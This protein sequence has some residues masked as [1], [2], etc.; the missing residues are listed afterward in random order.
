MIGKG[1]KY[2]I[3]FAHEHVP[4]RMPELDAIASMFGIT[5]KFIEQ[6]NKEPYAIVELAS[7]E[8]AKKL[9]SRSVLIRSV[10][11]LWTHAG[12]IDDVCDQVKK[13]PAKFWDAYSGEDQSFKFSVEIFGKRKVPREVKV[14]KIEKFDFLPLNGPIKMENPDHTYHLI[15][16][17]GIV[18]NYIPEKPHAVFFGRWIC[19]GQRFL[20]SHLALRTRKFIANTSMDPT[21]SVIMANMAKVKKSHLILD[22]F[23]GSGSLL[24]PAA[25]FGA[26]VLGT[27][28]DY[29][30]LHGKAK[31]SRCNEKQRA[32]DESVQAN[33]QQ[34]GCE[35]C[36]VDVV[37]ADASLPLWRAEMRLDAIITDPPYGIR[38]ATER[39]GTHKTYDI[40]GHLAAQ[41]V[42]SKV[43]YCLKDVLCD[44]LNFSAHHLCLNGR[45]VFWMPIYN[46]DFSE[47]SLP[48]HPCLKLIAYSE[49]SLS[50][51][52]SRLLI[53]MEKMSEPD[54]TS[55]AVM[56]S[57]AERFRE[58]YFAGTKGKADN[59]KS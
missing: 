43:A 2:L 20:K 21:L 52:S 53:T 23:V 31:P 30:L 58:R 14:E 48:Q 55:C 33:L 36:F 26:Y 18:P 22:P 4:F 19:D 42:P 51:H 5:I 27:D 32:D 10:I 16:Y 29:L 1:M 25:F 13:F 6:P 37:V 3:W 40:P 12:D 46:E 47:D 59:T 17:Y 28:L 35:Q 45:L 44:L 39:I 15:E 34:Y 11:E 38:E 7:E 57:T 54:E 24:V 8:D 50:K 9:A 56:S 49:Q 41:H